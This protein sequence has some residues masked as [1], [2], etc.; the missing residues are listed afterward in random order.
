MEGFMKT[1][2]QAMLLAA[3]MLA[4]CSSAAAPERPDAASAV[5]QQQ[6]YRGSKIIGAIVR[7]PQDR[8]IGQIKD[9]MLDSRRGEIAYAVVSFGGVMGTGRKYHAIPWQSLQASDDGKYYVLHADRETINQAPGF[10]KGKWPDMADRNWSA[11]IDRY[12]SRRVGN[13]RAGNNELPSGSSGAGA[14]AGN[15]GR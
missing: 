14:G 11:D 5:R 7:D 13:A 6:M 10:D 1:G 9:L 3:S 15:A 4:L 12:W 8:K 2:F